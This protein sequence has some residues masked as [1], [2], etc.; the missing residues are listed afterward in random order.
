MG[1]SQ[2]ETVV[3]LREYQLRTRLYMQTEGREGLSSYALGLAG[4]TG[5]VVEPIKKHLYHGQ[6][7]DHSNL[8]EEL[9]DVLFY[10]SAL[11]TLLGLSLEDI[12]NTNLTKLAGRYPGAGGV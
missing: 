8:C 4:E 3:A 6:A 9:G 2:H 10:V 12:A 5:E 1:D 11:A 7:L